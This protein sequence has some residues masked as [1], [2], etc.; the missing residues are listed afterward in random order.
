MH[1][2][3]I[4][5]LKFVILFFKTVLVMIINVVNVVNVYFVKVIYLRTLFFC[6]VG[7]AKASF[8]MTDGG[9]TL[10]FTSWVLAFWAC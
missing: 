6:R 1:R 4:T 3:K 7:R 9:T 8:P 10:P 2:A 5:L